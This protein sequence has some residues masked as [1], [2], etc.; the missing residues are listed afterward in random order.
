ML[1]Y[2]LSKINVITVLTNKIY[3]PNIYLD[4]LFVKKEHLL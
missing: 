4:L 1:Q 3:I 2:N